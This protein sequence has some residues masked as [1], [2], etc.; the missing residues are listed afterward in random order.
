M[1]SEST[2]TWRQQV[3]RIP[4]DWERTRDSSNLFPPAG[5][6]ILDMDNVLGEKPCMILWYEDG[7]D[8]DSEQ[9]V[10]LY[11]IPGSL[12]GDILRMRRNLPEISGHFE[13]EGDTIRKLDHPLEAPEPIEDHFDNIEDL[14][15]CLPLLDTDPAKHF[16]KRGKY[17]S[18]IENLLKCQGGACPGKPKSENL[19]RLL[20]K[21]PEGELV[22]E[23]LLTCQSALHGI[24][25]LATIQ[26][27]L[28]D[29]IA[30]LRC[31]HALGIIHRDLRLDN[32]L[33]SRDGGKRLV[34]CDLE[35]RWG[36]RSPSR[37][38]QGRRGRR[39]RVERPIRR[40]FHRRL[41][42]GHGLLQRP[43]RQL[44]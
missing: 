29:L 6:P 36:Q 35:G 30:A 39:G 11:D 12:S 26:R 5:K 9:C 7:P 28:L 43:A 44:C 22:F 33:F 1:A 17:R 16:V 3:E 8:S 13:I 32:C 10:R 15:D 20:G 2:E 24:P 27:W 38:C 25:S 14:L 19:I 18:E 40:V 41:H 31:L 4:N 42:Q 21:S 37:N 23:K 34:L